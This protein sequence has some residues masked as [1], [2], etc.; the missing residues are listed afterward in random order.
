MLHSL[1][2]RF[3]GV[4][5]Y[6]HAA[7]ISV[8]LLALAAIAM[9]AVVPVG[10]M[11]GT[12]ADG[13]PIVLCTAQG[14]AEIILDADGK[15]VGPDTPQDVTHHDTPCVFSAAAHLAAPPAI[16]EPAPALSYVV[17]GQPDQVTPAALS[18]AIRPV[19]A[20]APPAIS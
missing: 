12:S 5:R 11:P 8:F 6:G 14:L 2:M 17:L 7:R 13:T 3:F 15:P 16:F 19:Q 4:T 20:R 10:W 1:F 9:R 18:R